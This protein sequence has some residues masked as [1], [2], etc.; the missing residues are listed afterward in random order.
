MEITVSPKVMLRG[1]LGLPANLRGSAVGREQSG[2]LGNWQAGGGL[3]LLFLT[4]L[5]L[6]EP[7]GVPGGSDTRKHHRAAGGALL[8]NY[9]E[10]T[11]VQQLSN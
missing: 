10:A 8:M 4:Q 2:D 11:I 7:L 5:S 3:A 6:V 1:G 9:F